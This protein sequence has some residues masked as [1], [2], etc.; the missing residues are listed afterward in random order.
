VSRRLA[1]EISKQFIGSCKEKYGNKPHLTPEEIKESL[2]ESFA[3]MDQALRVGNSH[4][5]F[6]F[7]GSTGVVVVVNVLNNTA[8]TDDAGA[9]GVG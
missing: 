4:G 1:N 9:D 2:R 6:D 3:R 7:V 5:E 8:S